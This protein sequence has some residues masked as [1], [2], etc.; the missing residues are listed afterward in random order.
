[1]K[2]VVEARKKTVSASSEKESGPI[3][4]QIDE[5]GRSSNYHDWCDTNYKYFAT[6]TFGALA[7]IL[8]TRI[9]YTVP[10]V[11]EA[12]YIDEEVGAAGNARLREKAVEEYNKRRSNLLRVEQPK[13]FGALLQTLSDE[14]QL[15]VEVQP[16]Y[17]AAFQS[18]NGDMLYALIRQTHHTAIL[19][20]GAGAVDGGMTI[21]MKRQDEF[22]AVKQLSLIHI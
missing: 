6:E 15:K 16:G 22:A 18:Q 17:N 11:V 14:S 21:K 3:L 4:L 13:F 20:L 5:D 7:I 2:G 19:G 10:P 1:M 12:D 9:G 8:K